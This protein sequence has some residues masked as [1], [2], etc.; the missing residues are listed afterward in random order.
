MRT[1]Y[2]TPAAQ[3]PSNVHTLTRAIQ[4]RTRHTLSALN[5]ASPN[6]GWVNDEQFEILESGILADE[7]LDSSWSRQ[8]E[9]RH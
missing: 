1:V 7:T 5:P 6:T 8:H 3:R 2:Q 9:A 4:R